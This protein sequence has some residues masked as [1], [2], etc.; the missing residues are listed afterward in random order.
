M[1]SL[2]GHDGRIEGAVFTPDGQ[3]VVSCCAEDDQTVRLWDVA[4]G[5]L[6][7]VSDKTGQGFLALV[8]LPDN[9]HCLTTDKDGAVRIW[10]WTR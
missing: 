1:K 9:R 5:K 2:K 6:L 3:R 7:G 8:A 10:R 4:S